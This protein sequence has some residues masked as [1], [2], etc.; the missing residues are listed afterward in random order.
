LGPHS[1]GDDHRPE[2]EKERIA[3][4]DPLLALA[5]QLD[6]KKREE[7][8]GVN[9]AYLESLANELVLAPEPDEQETSFPPEKSAPIGEYSLARKEG[10]VRDQINHA[11]HSLLER[12]EK[13]LLIGEDLHDPYGGAFKVSKGISN[14]FPERSVSTP[15]SEAG[16]IGVGIGL[17]L[18]GYKP[19]VEIMFADFLSLCIDQLYNQ[20]VKL[21]WLGREKEFHMVVRT[22]GGGH[23]GYGPTHS[24]CVESLLMPIP[25]LTLVA[26]SHR[27]HV[28]ELLCA[29]LQAYGPVVFMENKLLYDVVCEEG[30]YET[31]PASVSDLSSEFFPTLVSQDVSEPD[32]TLVAFGGNVPLAEQVA[33]RLRE[34]EELTVALV[35]PSLLSPVPHDTLFSAL[36]GHSSLVFLEE[37]PTQGSFSSEAIAGL[38]ERGVRAESVLRIGAKPMPIPAARNLERVV[39]P[40]VDSVIEQIFEAFD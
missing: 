18:A 15:I 26:P 14:A 33:E 11:L 38:V 10:S 12:D 39:L 35:L 24:Q 4:R 31:V 3:N 8:E 37:S 28:G 16:I 22:P 40:Q 36:R 30:D 29:S 21:P 6:S 32:L 23:R 25:G 7:I 19:I 2:E 9:R 20:A 1:K 27:H 34:E 13:A 5:N 17:A